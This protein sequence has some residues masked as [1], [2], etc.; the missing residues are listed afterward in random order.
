MG[1]TGNCIK[2]STKTS[3]V[4]DLIQKQQKRFDEEFND[5]SYNLIRDCIKSLMLQNAREIYEDLEREAVKQIDK[6]KN[7][8]HHSESMAT[9]YQ[10]GFLYGVETVLQII[11][12]KHEQL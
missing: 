2:H 10:Q 11:K 4:N 1:S 9:H 12:T 5:T 7:Y 6:N 3:G 8:E